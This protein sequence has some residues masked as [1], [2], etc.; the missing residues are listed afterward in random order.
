[1]LKRIVLFAITWALCLPLV[2]S[3]PS[4]K[5]VKVLVAADHPDWTYKLGEKVKFTLA[6]FKNGNLVKDA[7]VRY[8]IG[9]EKQEPTKKETITL[10]NGSQ[11]IEGGTMTTSGFLRCIAIAEIDGKEY[12]NLS[13]AG[14]EPLSISPTVENPADFDTFWQE[15]KDE[16]AKKSL[17][18]L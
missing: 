10:A 6:V 18:I 17:D 14:F 8:E 4:E 12:R 2:F 3:Q 5:F 1:M 13:T 11:V 15:A 16:L 9:P 7:K